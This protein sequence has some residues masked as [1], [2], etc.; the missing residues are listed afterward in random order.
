MNAKE[1]I[2][3]TKDLVKISSPSGEERDMGNYLYN[4]LKKRFNVKKQKVGNRFNIIATNGNPKILFTTHMDTVP[5]K[6][7]YEEDNKYIYAR[8]ACDA[9]GP[10]AAMIVAMENALDKGYKDI[11]LIIDVGEEDDFSGIKEFIKYNK[12]KFNYNP[13]LVIVGEPTDF[14]II[15]GQKGLLTTTIETSGKTSHGSTPEKGICA[16]T[17]CLEI[18]TKLNKITWPKNKNLGKTTLNIGL[19]NGGISSNT[20]SDYAKAVIELRTTI[21]NKKILQKIRAVTQKNR[22]IITNNYE[23]KFSKVIPSLK[24]KKTIAPYFTEMLFWK[25]SIVYGPGKIKY[26]HADNERILKKDIIKAVRDYEKLIYNQFK[27]NN[28]KL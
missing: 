15:I 28:E 2:N 8:G 17:K 21:A 23:P 1:A 6:I 20:V 16:I 3:L 24:N 4:R 14:E 7:K 26:A 13:K 18:L 19:I 25:N 5:K 10:M 22:V 27:K 11:G 12:E 9:K